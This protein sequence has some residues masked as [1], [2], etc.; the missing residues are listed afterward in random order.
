MV[1]TWK[2]MSNKVLFTRKNGTPIKHDLTL[3]ALV[4]EHGN[5]MYQVYNKLNEPMPEL[6]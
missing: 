2:K 4:D 3:W 5:T 6:P 1:G